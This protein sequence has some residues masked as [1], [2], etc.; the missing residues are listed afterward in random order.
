MSLENELERVEF[1]E[2]MLEV[3]FG[4]EG[5]GRWGRFQRLE[6]WRPHPLLGET[7]FMTWAS[8][9]LL[10]LCIFESVSRGQTQ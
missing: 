2:L 8:F 10:C 3:D 7:D 6:V 9:H 1:G 5:W 4:G